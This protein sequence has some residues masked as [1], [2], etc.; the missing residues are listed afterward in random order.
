MVLALT[1]LPPGALA[2]VPGA[3]PPQA[4]RPRVF[5][6]CSF[7][8]DFDHFRRE[9]GFVDWVRDR[10][11]AD[12][13]ALGTAQSTGGGGREY[14]YEMIGLRGL[15]GRRDTLHYVSRATDTESETRAGITRM[16]GMGLV[17]FAA[18]FGVAS[19]IT[20]S[21]KAPEGA[22]SA[23]PAVVRDPWNFWVFRVRMGGG[24]EGEQRQS[25]VS[26]DGG[27]SA[28]RVT[29]RLKISMNGNGRYSR[30]KYELDS[31]TTYINT[32]RNYSQQLLVVSSLGPRWSAGFRQ[33]VSSSTFNNQDLVF[34]AGPA[35]EFDVYPYRESSRRQFTLSYLPGIAYYNYEE[36]T[37][38]G[39]ARET[40][41]LHRFIAALSARQPW[42]SVDVSLNALQYLHD[43]SK[44]SIRLFAGFNLRIVRG[45]NFNAFGSVARIKDQLN[46][47]GAG[48]TPEEILLEQ[49]QLG[50]NYSFWANF[51]LSYSFGSIFNNVVNP[52]MNEID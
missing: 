16:L 30:N 20:V 38:F 43:L 46:W 28:N 6:D 44:H 10:S 1:A 13:H 40:L 35:L 17:R 22:D 51:N 4:D 19:R 49:R 50:T 21:Y 29:E 48:L 25:D 31:V 52:R 47:P 9:I 36:I 23:K 11:D 12:V 3:P 27:L 34:E 7:F 24:F 5:L 45:L 32:R 37:L 33:R 42:G 18:G 39:K 26:V 15:A 2:Q 8:C 14:I 41:P